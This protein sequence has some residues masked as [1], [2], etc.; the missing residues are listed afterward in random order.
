[1]SDDL[2]GALPTMLPSLE[3]ALSE[4]Q[5]GLEPIPSSPLSLS[6]GLHP[7]IARLR[8]KRLKAEMKRAER[9]KRFRE[10]TEK[11]R[12]ERARGR[13]LHPMQKVE[14]RRKVNKKRVEKYRSDPRFRYR[15]WIDLANSAA[16]RSLPFEDW[17][18]VMNRRMPFGK[19]A[20]WQ[21]RKTVSLWRKDPSQPYSLENL[22][23]HVT[24]GKDRRYLWKKLKKL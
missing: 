11:V 13:N 23:D 15:R 2:L 1:M 20:L 22:E 9:E 3:E 12:S 8:A 10:R 18:F 14:K 5:R 24:I 6:D 19:L 4:A 7:T 21:T 17:F 16:K